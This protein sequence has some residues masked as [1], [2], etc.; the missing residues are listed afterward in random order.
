MRST[1]PH[2]VYAYTDCL[3]ITLKFKDGTN[4]AN[5]GGY[6]AYYSEYSARTLDSCQYTSYGA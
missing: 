3:T 2:D 6:R 4:Y 1:L 5:R